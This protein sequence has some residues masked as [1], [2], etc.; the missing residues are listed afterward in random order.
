MKKK[1]LTI[2]TVVLVMVC[3]LTVNV[4]A[5]D[6][7]G[8][9]GDNVAWSFDEATGTLT[10]S[11]EGEMTADS[12]RPSG[13]EQ[14]Y[15]FPWDYL[16][17]QIASV[18]IKNGVTNIC[19]GAFDGCR[20]LKTVSIPE[21]VD[22]IGAY[23]FEYCEALK[24]VEIP[25]GVERVGRNAFAS[26]TA[27]ENVVIAETVKEIKAYAF[28]ECKSLKEIVIPEG[29]EIIS[30]GTFEGCK[31]LVT[32]SLPDTLKEIAD[33]GFMF[34]AFD[35]C[36]SLKS[37]RIPNGVEKLGAYAFYNCEK[38]KT[39]ELPQSLR[40]IGASAFAM[41][42][43]LEN[44]EI[45]TGVTAIGEYAFS[46]CS[47]VKK[48]AIPAGISEIPDGTFY[49]CSR[50]AEILI[51]DSVM[52]I[53][54]EVFHTFIPQ[55]THMTVLYDG[56]CLQWDAIEIGDGNNMLVYQYLQCEHTTK[57]IPGVEPTCTQDGRTDEII[58][59]ACGRTLQYAGKMYA[60]GHN[61]EL[62]N[63]KEASCEE[64]GYTGDKVCRNC[65]ETV[66]QGENIA[67]LGHKTELRN[68]KEA[69]CEEVGYSGDEICRICDKTVKQGAEIKALGHEE[70]ILP[71]TPASCEAA[72]ITEGLK[73]KRCGEVLKEQ[74]ELPRLGH[75][76]VEN[77][78]NQPTCGEY[79]LAKYICKNDESHFYVDAVDP[80][81]DHDYDIAT[82]ICKVCEAENP[83]FVANPFTDV[84]ETDWFY[85]PVLWAFKSGVTGGKTADTFAPNEGC[86]RAQVVTFLWAANGK[87][88]PKS[89]VN[90]FADV[91]ED[92]WY[93]KP[94]L[95]AVENGI[96]GG[97]ADGKFGPDQTC[98][99]AQ[100]VTFLYAAM[101]KPAVDGVGSF[102]DVA[103]TDWF[104]KPVIWAAENEVTGGIGDG[105]F[106]PNNTCTRAQVVTFLYKVYG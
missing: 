96:T 42:K 4:S 103:D 104:A 11:G 26:C 38:L 19:G 13:Q 78:L 64:T 58:C 100:I 7:S 87:P 97:I 73:C 37:I 61:T 102:S 33:A 51:P 70:E 32:V 24:T 45:P 88:E 80:T 10:V 83:D 72:G 50:L 63:K 82:G 41:C 79:G 55:N 18:E 56:T 53:G 29:V 2:L 94:V 68:K 57:T 90:I 25:A 105:K 12:Y 77:I 99:R 20:S 101:K 69:S 5:A 95:W 59:E 16:K 1:L 8:T 22:E 106:G 89:M 6:K 98:T 36:T 52:S 46:N 43:Q 3:L 23:A 93:L 47:Q 86:T 54:D 31:D 91:S 40:S 39:V 81:G 27:L 44:V 34:G 76:Y 60:Y 84:A 92:A 66:E 85:N 48:L 28:M 71:G 49:G 30:A 17:E 74:V 75:D 14:Y 15:T 35:D 21:S 9:C 62:R 65:S 67:A